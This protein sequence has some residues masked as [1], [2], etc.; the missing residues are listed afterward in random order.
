MGGAREADLL[1]PGVLGKSVPVKPLL[2]VLGHNVDHMLSEELLREQSRCMIV[3]ITT[4]SVYN[5]TTVSIT[6]NM[7][8][9]C[10]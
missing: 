7:H 9:Q 3:T 1:G 2:I 8:A 4:T 6:R 5:I 10:L